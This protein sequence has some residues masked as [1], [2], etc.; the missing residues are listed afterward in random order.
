MEEGL[1]FGDSSSYWQLE[2]TI[3]PIQRPD[4]LPLREK[5]VEAALS[6]VSVLIFPT[7]FC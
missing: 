5:E 7:T 4:A 2:V 1:F 6:Y 3:L